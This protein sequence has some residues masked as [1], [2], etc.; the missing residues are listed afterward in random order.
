MHEF[1]EYVGDFVVF[2]WSDTE[3]LSGVHFPFV[4]VGLHEMSETDTRRLN[5]IECAVSWNYIQFFFSFISWNIH[6]PVENVGL[7]AFERMKISPLKNHNSPLV[8]M[9]SLPPLNVRGKENEELNMQNSLRVERKKAEKGGKRRP[10]TQKEPTTKKWFLV[11]R[12][13]NTHHCQLVQIF[14]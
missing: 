14:W 1:V 10:N 4:F 12:M 2:F 5:I 3:L 8:S 9:H 11:S 13:G 6:Q 7:A